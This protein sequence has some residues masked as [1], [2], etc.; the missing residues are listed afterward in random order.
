MSKTRF[1]QQT[2]A[3]DIKDPDTHAAVRDLR[4]A[5]DEVRKVEGMDGRFLTATTPGD[6]FSKFITI[7]NGAVTKI[8]HNLGR[9]LRGWR[10]EDR[11]LPASVAAAGDVFRVEADA[12]GVRC[13]DS[14][15]VWLMAVGYGGTAVSGRLWVY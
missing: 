9:P 3:R 6:D 4:L 12:A 1:Q 2:R 13:D 8:R 7:T 10:L 15:E 14:A 11:V 5:I